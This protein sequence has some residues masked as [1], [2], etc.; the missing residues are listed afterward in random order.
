MKNAV[1]SLD[2]FGN[3]LSSDDVTIANDLS[4]SR[5]PAKWM[6]MAGDTAP[7]DTTSI[8]QWL[9]DIALRV[10]HFERIL[11]VVISVVFQIVGSVAYTKRSS[12]S[13]Q[14]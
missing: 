11:A 10:G 12:C 5:I 3:R 14:S 13:F 9:N 4:R 8:S 7:P 6:A 1:E 2:Q